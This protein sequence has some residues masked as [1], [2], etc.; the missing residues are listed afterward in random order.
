MPEPERGSNG[1]VWDRLDALPK[2][3]RTSVDDVEPP[4]DTRR[5]EI[6]QADP[7]QQVQP[8]E[9]AP[10]PDDPPARRRRGR[11][12][13]WLTALGVLLVVFVV[14]PLMTAWWMWNKVDKIDLGDSLAS[15][16]SATNYL[17]V[18]T[19]SRD[20]FDPTSDAADDVGL[21][22]TGERS[23]TMLVLHVG[24][25]ERRLLSIPRDLWVQFP[26]GTEDRINTALV[27][28]GPELLVDTVQRSLGIPIH[29]YLQVDLAGFIGVVDA[30]G[31][32]ELDV[33]QAVCDPKSGLDI[34]EP[35]PQDFDGVEALEYVRSRTYV[36]FD[37][38]ATVGMTC[39]QIMAAGLGSPDG[40]AD[41]GRVERQREF[42]TTLMADASGR[43]NPITLLRVANGLS[44]G[45]QVDHTMGMWDAVQLMRRLGATDA[46]TDTLG[47]VQDATINGKSVLVLNTVGAEPLLAEY[48]D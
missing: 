16:G 42:L 46:G 13:W 4:P 20:S 5:Y 1:N 8:R 44:D 22:V 40:R 32:V 36:T 33:P 3:E 37:P 28:G 10:T 47:P 17:I 25:G 41:L 39:E 35:G 18:G 2:M 19:D 26:D 6:P 14:L 38:A 9:H 45:L 7:D 31:G 43:K 30:L 11:M 27:F 29:H 21:D 23:D 24:G 15:G 34:R 12:R 48:R